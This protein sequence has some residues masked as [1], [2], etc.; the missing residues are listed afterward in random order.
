MKRFLRELRARQPV[1]RERRWLFVPYDQLA[2]EIGPLARED[3]GRL[4]IVLLENRW[5]AARRPYHRQKLALLWA[6]QRHFALEQAERG[7]AVRY[8]MVEG[9]FAEALR[10]LLKA[11][12]PM[13]VMDPAERELRRDLTELTGEG[14]E[15]IPHEGWLT[16]HAQFRN[17]LPA[18]PWR[19]DRFYREVR[20]ATGVL[21]ARGQPVGG[22][23]SFDPENRSAWKGNPP[24]PQVPVCQ[25]DPITE[26]V[27]ALVEREFRAHPGVV[28]A[29]HLPATRADAEAMWAWAKRECLPHF[30]PYED[31]MSGESR[32]LFHTQ[33]SSLLNLHRLLPA[34]VL[35]EAEAAPA[36]LPSREGFIRQVLGWREYVRHVHDASDGF[37]AFPAGTPI[38]ATPGDAGYR[39][40]S[41]QEWPG[42]TAL[43][44]LDGGAAPSALGGSRPL[45]RAYWGAP[46]G[47]HCLDTVVNSVWE[48]GWSHHI[49][50][51]VILAG[52]ANLLDVSPRALTDWFW[53]AYTDA[54]D[55]VVEPNVLGLGTF[56]V[57]DLM[58]TK[59]YVT[60]ASYID[61]MSDYCRSCQFNPKRTCPLTPLYWAFL[62][63]HQEALR[64]NPRMTLALSGLRKRPTAQRGLDQAVLRRIAGVLWRGTKLQLGDVT[65]RAPGGPFAA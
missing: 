12:G 11:L 8:E 54:Y 51:L 45:P 28:R 31:A 5:Q 40:W 2:S 3:P 26:E 48:E 33:L 13:R 21:M 7:V 20:R 43:A 60:G 34:R 53:V 61:R 24:A 58:S 36:P 63:R 19:M 35:R 59:P 30:G 14:L 15:V 1:D 47:L 39:Q 4:G 65:P 52:L 57:G 18:P 32:S 56:A 46:S 10:P 9:P 42:N 37:R 23:Y 17:A 55:W 6:N 22:K 29:E 49:T 41:G 25:P 62:A 16:T 64:S 27:A 44:P 38:A 50:R